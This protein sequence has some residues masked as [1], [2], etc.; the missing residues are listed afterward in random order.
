MECGVKIVNL[1]VNHANHMLS[2]YSPRQ[3]WRS[4]PKLREDTYK[5]IKDHAEP[6]L[7]MGMLP[8]SKPQWALSKAASAIHGALFL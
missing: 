8:E 2:K 7:H 5:D 4:A 3:F 1:A 6:K